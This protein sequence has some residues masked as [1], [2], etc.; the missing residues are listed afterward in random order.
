[1]ADIA[2]TADAV[3]TLEMTVIIPCHGRDAIT[4]LQSHFV[5]RIGELFDAGK[6]IFESIAVLRIVHG[7]RHN[8]PI[9]MIFRRVLCQ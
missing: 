2:G 9:A 4:V 6:T 8:L 3:V 5:E 1:M 7:N